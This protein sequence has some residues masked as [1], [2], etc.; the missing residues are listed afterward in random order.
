VT[1]KKR[2]WKGD[3]EAEV[4]ES[5]DVSYVAASMWKGAGVEIDGY[6]GMQQPK[7]RFSFDFWSRNP[8]SGQT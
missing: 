1:S 7:K 8:V 3:S 6:R 5:R 2:L 4:V